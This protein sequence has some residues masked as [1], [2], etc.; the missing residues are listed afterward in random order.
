MQ[1]D[2]Q[3]IPRAFI[4]FLMTSRPAQLNEVQM[5]AY[6]AFWYDSTIQKGGHA[7]FL[8]NHGSEGIDEVTGS[9]EQ[10][11][12]GPQADL[13]REAGARWQSRDRLETRDL[14]AY[15]KATSESEFLDLDSMYQ[16]CVPSISELLERY[17]HENV[18]Q[19]IQVVEEI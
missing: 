2:P 15:V 3:V 4:E 19:F 1:A 11:G 16:E 12:A 5:M 10:I 18:D 17:L 7:L 9:L 14:S 6:R 13:L 8:A